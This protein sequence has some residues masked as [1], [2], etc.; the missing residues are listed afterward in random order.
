M[1]F[2]EHFYVHAPLYSLSVLQIFILCFYGIPS[3][4]LKLTPCPRNCNLYAENQI[5]TSSS[6]VPVTPHPFKVQ[7]NCTPRHQTCNPFLPSSLPP[8]LLLL[9]YQSP[10]WS[11]VVSSLLIMTPCPIT[12]PNLSYLRLCQ[13][14]V[15]SAR[16]KVWVM[17]RNF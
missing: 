15:S 6:L 10:K 3:F 5:L 7:G 12:S 2:I 14:S 8:I 11:L 13:R 9:T 1:R 4:L 17:G 16:S